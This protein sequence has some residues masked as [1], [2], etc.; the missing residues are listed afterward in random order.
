M[1]IM[2]RISIYLM[3]F[4]SY[5]KTIEYDIINDLKNICNFLHSN[6]TLLIELVLDILAKAKKIRVN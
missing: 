4:F 6:S 1:I 5:F 2:E 3:L